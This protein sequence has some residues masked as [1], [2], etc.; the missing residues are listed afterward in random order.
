MDLMT[1]AIISNSHL[2]SH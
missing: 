2:S 1:S